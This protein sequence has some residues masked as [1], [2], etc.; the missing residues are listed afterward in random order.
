[1]TISGVCS[2]CIG[3]AVVTSAMSVYNGGTPSVSTGTATCS[4][5]KVVVG[6]GLGDGTFVGAAGGY[7]TVSYPSATNAWYVKMFGG[8]G[9]T[10]DPAALV[11]AVCINP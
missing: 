7:P 4:G 1:M 8:N 9:S 3:K 6:G 5:N 11:Y 10:A 2:G